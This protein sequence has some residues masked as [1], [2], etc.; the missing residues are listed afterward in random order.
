MRGCCQRD[1][2]PIFHFD[3]IRKNVLQYLLCGFGLERSACFL[4]LWYTYMYLNAF[5]L[6][7]EHN[8]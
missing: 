2:P 7:F 8:K 3:V 4:S 5:E 1:T 6:D